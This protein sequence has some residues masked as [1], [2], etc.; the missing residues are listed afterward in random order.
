MLVYLEKARAYTA[1]F[2]HLA[3][4]KVTTWVALGT[5]GLTELA[6]K[7]D[8]AAALLPHFLVSHKAEILAAATLVPIWT[9]IRRELK[10][11]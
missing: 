8:S 1:K 3:K 2:Y 7:W 6:D 4:S 11:S 9:R 10:G 5:A